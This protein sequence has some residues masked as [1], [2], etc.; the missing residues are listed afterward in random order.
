MKQEVIVITETLNGIISS[1]KVFAIPQGENFEGARQEAI[2]KAEKVFLACVKENM[3]SYTE[4]DYN[5]L[6][7]DG[8]AE[9]DNG[10]EITLRWDEL[11]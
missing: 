2:D 7:D 11:Q 6:L 4:E 1:H 10:Y 8:Y 3:P 5:D 9:D